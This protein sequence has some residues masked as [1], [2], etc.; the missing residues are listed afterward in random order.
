MK[1][2]HGSLVAP[3]LGFLL[4]LILTFGAYILVE[5]HNNAAHESLP[6]LVLISTII[7]FALLQLAVQLLF[8]LH[9][10]KGKSAR[11][12]SLIFITTFCGIILIVVGSIWIMNHL[13]YNMT[14]EQTSQYIND[15]S[16]F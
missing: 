13:N 3:V 1:N 11:L 5:I 12:H 15:Q 6:S 14:P 8:F 9:M 4:S 10:G 7:L 2:V 16:G